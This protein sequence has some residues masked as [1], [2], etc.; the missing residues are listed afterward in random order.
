MPL[1]LRVVLL[2][3]IEDFYSILCIHITRAAPYRRRGYNVSICIVSSTP[4]QNKPL[5]R[6]WMGVGLLH[7]GQSL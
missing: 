4:R 6:E 5:K 7:D 1:L 3:S 2:R